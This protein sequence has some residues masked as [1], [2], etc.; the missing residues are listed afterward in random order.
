MHSPALMNTGKDRPRSMGLN[1]QVRSIIRWGGQR[2]HRRGMKCVL[3]RR[4]LRPSG[5]GATVIGPGM[6]IAGFGP[7]AAGIAEPND[8]AG[9]PAQPTSRARV[10]RITAANLRPR[11]VF[12]DRSSKSPS[13]PARTVSLVSVQLNEARH[14]EHMT[15]R[16]SEMP[17]RQMPT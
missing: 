9:T 2:C 1:I 5:I 14:A 3:G 4:D 6:V 7:R 8:A 16:R 13:W 11:Q 17:L 15:A 12:D 10:V